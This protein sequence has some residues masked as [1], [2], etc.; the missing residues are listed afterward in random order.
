MSIRIKVK[1]LVMFVLFPLA[2]L[3]ALP[4]VLPRITAPAERPASPESAAAAN[5]AREE[6]LHTLDTSSGTKRMTLIRTKIIEPGN[7]EQPYHYNVYIGAS[8]SQWSRNDNEEAPPPLLPADKLQLLKEYVLEGPVDGYLR[9]AVKQLLYEYDALGTGSDGDQML[10]EVRARIDS[11]TRLYRELLLLQAERALNAGNWTVA[12][13]LLKQA[14]SPGD[15]GG[16]ELDARCV[17]LG[18]RLLFAEGS[19]SEALKLVN[20]GLK[21]YREVREENYKERNAGNAAGPGTGDTAGEPSAVAGSPDAEAAAPQNAGGFSS[22]TER[23]LTALQTA[24]EA[25][26]DSGNLAP[27][28]LSGTLTYSDGTPV[29]RAGIFLRA[30]SEVSHSVFYDLEPY[31]IVTDTEGRFSFSGVIPGFYQLHLGLSFEQIDGWTWPVQ[32]DD[33]TYIKQ[34]DQLTSNI[35]LQPL[36]ELKSPVNSQII[37][38]N[39]VDFEWE[40]V[41]GAASY[42]LSGT[43]TAEG[44][45]FSYVVRQHITDNRV[46]V[47]VEELYNSGGFST[48]SSG[49]GWQSIEASSL[50][51]FADPS[52]RFSWSIEAYDASGRVITR[53]NGYRLNEDTVGNLP[54]FYLQ[55]RNLTASDQLVKAGKLEQALEAY[56]LDFAA[57]PQDAHALKM[58]VHLMTAKA[59]YTKDQTLEAETIPLLVKLVELRPS[60]DYVFNLAIYYYE[61]SDW[62]SYS[63]Y[64]SRFLELRGQKPQSYDRAINASALMF[65]GQLDEARRE[66]A[67]SLAEDPSHRFIGSYLAAELAAGQ[68][69]EAAL[70][71][72]WRYPQH[73][74]G[75]SAASWAKLISRM[76]AERAGAPE[77]YDRLLKQ[78]LEQY[79]ARSAQLKQWTGSGDD[80]DS[81]LKAFMKAVLEVG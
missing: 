29:A 51:G 5:R 81:A 17:W 70:Q 60:A 64:Y 38:G 71:L 25:A 48:G 36:L 44:S 16:D 21:N 58:L 4:A 35:V 63:R 22:D 65:Q 20:S 75:S 50:L 34:N 39:S 19:S 10:S 72:A 28:T 53:S 79:T 13:A 26:V 14:G 78:K 37:T 15:S 57:D 77:A 31:Q 11:S 40:T 49:D 61:H 69:L 1:H 59:S 68:P 62:I 42:N 33:W 52:S 45:A 2:L 6:L 47:P 24:I 67:L 23:Q 56:R 41:P 7:I 54:F 30:E 8:S 74:F 27:A 43:V 80:R 32:M 46:S 66:F 76:Q 18:A 73:S 12:D 9:T 3:A 55:S